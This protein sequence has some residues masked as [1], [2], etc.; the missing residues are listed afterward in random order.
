MCSSTI[1]PVKHEKVS[2]CILFTALYQTF[3][4]SFMKD[5]CIHLAM[6]LMK[7]NLLKSCRFTEI[8]MQKFPPSWSFLLYYPLTADLL[9]SACRNSPQLENFLTSFLSSGSKVV[10]YTPQRLENFLTSFLSS[11]SKVMEYTPQS[12][13]W[14]YNAVH[15]GYDYCHIWFLCSA[16]VSV[17][18]YQ[19]WE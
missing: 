2:H 13:I 7:K 9:K 3:Y 10:E 15:C 19:F 14:C 5:L 1:Q 11:G 8:C 17:H 4:W 16:L 12:D 18:C 6:T